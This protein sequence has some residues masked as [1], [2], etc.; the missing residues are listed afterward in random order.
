MTSFSPHEDRGHGVLGGAFTGEGPAK[1]E[2]LIMAARFDEK[3]CSFLFD[4]L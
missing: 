1:K 4:F 3:M 2:D